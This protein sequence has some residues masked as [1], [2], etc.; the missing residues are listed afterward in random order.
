MFYSH[1]LRS[2]K[3]ILIYKLIFGINISLSLHSTIIQQLKKE[4]YKFSLLDMWTHIVK[5]IRRSRSLRM[6]SAKGRALCPLWGSRTSVTWRVTSLQRRI[7]ILMDRWMEISSKWPAWPFDNSPP[8]IMCQ[9]TLGYCPLM[10]KDPEIRY[11]LFLLEQDVLILWS[12]FF[13]CNRHGKLCN[14]YI[15]YF[16]KNWNFDMFSSKMNIM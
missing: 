5:I 4:I 7:T 11:L 3:C 1:A 2:T 14:D 8:S 12:F 6:S 9:S 15:H 16:E 13:Y 10:R